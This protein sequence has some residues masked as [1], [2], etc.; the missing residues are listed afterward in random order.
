MGLG[1]VFLSRTDVDS[2]SA[3]PNRL[4]P[5]FAGV[6]DAW[7]AKDDEITRDRLLTAITPAIAQA[8]RDIPGADPNY[9][10]MR[11]K[12][13]AMNAMNKYDPARSSLNT[14]LTH[15]LLPL[16]RTA[17]QQ[18]NVLGLPDRLLLN[19]QQLESAGVELQD[20]LGR[21][22]TTGELSDRLGVSLKQ[23]GRIRRSSHARNSGSYLTADEEGDLS[24]P[25]EVMRHLPDV[26]RHQYV[27]SALHN[28]PKSVLIYEHDQS[29]HGRRPLSTAELAGQLGLSP[30]AISQRR[31]R[32][33]EIANNAEREIYGD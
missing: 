17:R 3:V 13:L 9:M 2:L 5:E 16:R 1:N 10:T 8:V 24:G 25:G 15:Q 31:N 32:I 20:E 22:P 7:K 26:Y 21:M 28:D 12:I 19:S 6:Y 30:G 14:F 18:M 29:L 4:E 11:G 23:I 33:A 27:L